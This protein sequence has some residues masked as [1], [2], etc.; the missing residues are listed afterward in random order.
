[1]FTNVQLRA[2]R[3]PISVISAHGIRTRDVPWDMRVA[4]KHD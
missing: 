1:M 2:A 4:T 3:V